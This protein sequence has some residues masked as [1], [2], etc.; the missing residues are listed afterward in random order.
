MSSAID[1]GAR[2]AQEAGRMRRAHRVQL[3]GAE[4]PARRRSE[5]GGRGGGGGGVGGAEAGCCDAKVANREI[6]VWHFV[7]EKG[8]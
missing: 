7:I 6:R 8:Y 3:A 2:C 4:V 1:L 5:R